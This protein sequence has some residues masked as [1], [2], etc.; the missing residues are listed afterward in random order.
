V[1]S[2]DTHLEPGVG[3]TQP[4]LPARM[5]GLRVLSESAHVVG[6]AERS[7]VFAISTSGE[8]TTGRFIGSAA[9]PMAVRAC[10]PASG[11]YRAKI[12]WEK[13]FITAVVC[14]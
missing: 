12:N 13:G 14:G 5:T 11:P 2:T 10:A 7:Y 4:G 8:M 9:T 6:S 1:S 3:E